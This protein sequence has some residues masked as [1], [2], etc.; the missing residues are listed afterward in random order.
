M[1]RIKSS[2]LFRIVPTAGKKINPGAAVKIIRFR[3]CSK[4]HVAGFCDMECETTCGPTL[5]EIFNRTNSAPDQ[6]KLPGLLTWMARVKAADLVEELSEAPKKEPEAKKDGWGVKTR[7]EE[8]SSPSL[9]ELL[10]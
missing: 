1:G 3:Y 4:V 9:E 8:Q 10:G 6:G 2:E 5:T 7:P